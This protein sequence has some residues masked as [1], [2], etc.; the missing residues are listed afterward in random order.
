MCAPACVCAV[1]AL[2][3][4]CAHPCLQLGVVL[5]ASV[6]VVAVAVLALLVARLLLFGLGVA[7]RRPGKPPSVSFTRTGTLCMPL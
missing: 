4:K 6:A 7:L 3:S 1:H 5:R 2:N